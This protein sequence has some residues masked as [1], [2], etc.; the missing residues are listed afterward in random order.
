[1]TSLRC[2]FRQTSLAAAVCADPSVRLAFSDEIY[3]LTLGNEMSRD[4]LLSKYDELLGV[5]PTSLQLSPP[6]F[7]EQSWKRSS[8]RPH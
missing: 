8:C 5:C 2:V 3:W 7:A 6:W 1:M 4:N